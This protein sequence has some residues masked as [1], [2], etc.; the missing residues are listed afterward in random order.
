MDHQSASLSLSQ[1]LDNDYGLPATAC[2]HT[3]LLAINMLVPTI[4][5]QGTRIGNCQ[6]VMLDHCHACRKEGGNGGGGPSY[7]DAVEGHGNAGSYVRDVRTAFSGVPRIRPQ[8]QDRYMKILVVGESGEQCGSRRM[9][10]CTALLL[11]PA[12]CMLSDIPVKMH[13]A[14]QTTTGLQAWARRP[15][16]RTCLQRMPRTQI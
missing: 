12:P 14:Q 4:R 2:K 11:R 8:W 7:G 3:S 16:S 6:H 13:P 1:R 9:A 15:S 5:H 10:S